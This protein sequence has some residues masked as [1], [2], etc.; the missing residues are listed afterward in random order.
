M[1]AE[2]VSASRNRPIEP[3]FQNYIK[4]PKDLKL[5]ESKPEK[6]QKN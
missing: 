4:V 3:I 2:L 5:Q 1:C 6:E